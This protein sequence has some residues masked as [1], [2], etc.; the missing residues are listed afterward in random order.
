MADIKYSK[1]LPYLMVEVPGCTEPLAEQ[2]V[3]ETVIEFCANSHI[4]R[5]RMDPMTVRQNV[6]DYDLDDLPRDTVLTKVQ[7]VFIDAD[8]LEPTSE[9]WLDANIHDW[10]RRAGLPQ[11]YMQIDPSYMTLVLRPDTTRAK[12]MHVTVSVQ[13]SRD[14][15][16]FPQ[17][18]AD[19]YQEDILMGA[20]ARLMKQ[21]SQPW[22]NPTLSE[23]YRGRFV[24]ATTTAADIS[25]R[26]LVRTRLR[27]TPHH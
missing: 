10:R 23:F 25:A 9:D 27:T 17:W 15:T 4:W 14:S 8:R 2:V 22:Y 18:I 12:A 3:R 11:F 24:L 20:K 16:A 26:S 6:A 21:Q 13:P 5:H 19:Q 7:S 1:L